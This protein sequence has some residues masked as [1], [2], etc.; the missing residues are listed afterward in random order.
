MRAWFPEKAMARMPGSGRRGA[1]AASRAAYQA[2][3]HPRDDQRPNQAGREHGRELRGETVAL[4]QRLAE[5]LND[6]AT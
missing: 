4:R 3:E 5:W 2:I 6:E 1:G